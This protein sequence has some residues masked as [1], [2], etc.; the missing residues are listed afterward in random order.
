[1][2]TKRKRPPKPGTINPEYLHA[3]VER[4]IAAI[5]LTAHETRQD[6]IAAV[7]YARE[8][9]AADLEHAVMDYV[10]DM[11]KTPLVGGAA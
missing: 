2:A 3:V 8:I 1:M 6:T 4:V 11:R 9:P 10:R 7:A 5:V